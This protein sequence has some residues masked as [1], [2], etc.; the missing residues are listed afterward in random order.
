MQGRP[1]SLVRCP[2]GIEGQCFFQ[3]HVGVR[4]PA[5]VERVPIREKNGVDDYLAVTSIDG[6]LGLAQ[7]GNVEFHTWGSHVPDVEHA[8]GSHN[9]LLTVVEAGR[10]AA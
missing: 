3:K 2:Q 8:F 9:F 10:L 7:Y 4:L 6:L 5:G 1:L